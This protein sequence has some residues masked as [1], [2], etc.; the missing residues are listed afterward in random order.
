MNT[1]DYC[2]NVS[3]ELSIWKNELSKEIDRI[4]H[5][6]SGEKQHIHGVVEDLRMLESE[7]NSRIDQLKTECDTSWQP[8][9]VK[10]IIDFS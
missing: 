6:P 9:K 4:S 3:E 1:N 2:K 8:E 10:D 7:M 5:M